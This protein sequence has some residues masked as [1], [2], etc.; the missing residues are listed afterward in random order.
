MSHEACIELEDW[1]CLTD[2]ITGA[3]P[4]PA[5]RYDQLQH[6]QGGRP[7][8]VAYMEANAPEMEVRCVHGYPSSIYILSQF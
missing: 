7:V 4:P 8:L 2:L 5:A 3:P 6:L 1:F